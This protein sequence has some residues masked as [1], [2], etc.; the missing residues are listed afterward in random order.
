MQEISEMEESTYRPVELEK[1]REMVPADVCPL[2]L[3]KEVDHAPT[4]QRTAKALATRVASRDPRIISLKI[5]QI[6][7]GL[8]FT[9]RKVGPTPLDAPGGNGNSFPERAR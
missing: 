2:N 9:A 3:G 4:P 8:N 7:L 5:V 6:G 1:I